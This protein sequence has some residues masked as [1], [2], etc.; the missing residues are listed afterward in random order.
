MPSS[1]D[2]AQRHARTSR[3]AAEGLIPDLPAVLRSAGLADDSLARA[4][5][6]E[7][8]TGE[9]LEK[10]VTRLGLISEDALARALGAALDLPV[11]EPERFPTEALAVPNIS[12]AFLHDRRALPLWLDKGRVVVALA[13]P[14]DHDAVSGLAFATGHPVTRVIARGGDIDAAIDRLYRAEPAD[15][16]EDEIDDADLERL[17]DLVS[18]APVI[19]AVNRLIADAVDARASDIHLEPTDDRLAVRFRIDGMLRE[20]PAKPAAMRAPIVSRIKVMANLNIAERRLP[21]DG[22]LRLTVRGHEIDLR[23]ATAPSIHGESVVMRILD[24]SNLS[25]D[26]KT[27]GFDPDLEAQFLAALAQPHGIMLVTGPTGSGK[28]TTL[29][30][31]LAHLNAPDRKLTTIED[32]IEYRLPGVVQSQINPTIG[33][34]FSTALRS[35]LRQDPDVMMVGEIRDTETAQI[36][37]Q[38]ALTGHMILSTLHTNTAAGAVTRLLDMGVEPFLLSSVLTGVLAQRLVRRLCPHCREPYEADPALLERLGI[39]HQGSGHDTFYR[40]VGCPRCKGSGYAGRMAVFEFIRIDRDISALILR[41][42]DTRAIAEQA[43][44]AG[45]GTLR[46]DGIAKARRGLTALEEVLRVASED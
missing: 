45:Y 5:L 28:T 31:A 10:I 19:R 7:A 11:I 36:A 17:K 34:T 15:Q 12:Q 39:A 22:R 33:Y 18:D 14:L 35:F 6:V 21:Q 32:P 27:L 25:L 30:A 43:A 2:P 8:E 46:A 26:P 16:V 24:R 38:A 4:R 29:Y 23:V 13:N 41:R 40:P 3:E 20:M 42:A 1:T 37:V 44:R 9:T